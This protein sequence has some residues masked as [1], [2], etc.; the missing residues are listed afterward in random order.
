[1]VA[2]HHRWC[3]HGD[4]TGFAL[5]HVITLFVDQTD[6]HVDAGFAAGAE[7]LLFM[8]LG[9][10]HGD[11]ERAF[12]LAVVLPEFLP[13]PGGHGFLDHRAGHRRGAVDHLA[14]PAHVD[15]REAGV[16]EQHLQHGGHHVDGG[17]ALFL[18]Q[19]QE[20]VRVEAG[21]DHGARAA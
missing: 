21:H 9:A 4:F 6:L 20:G 10:Q 17:D 5:G 13:A 1:M 14:Q 3:A 16:A 19:F 2:G 15:L 11:G 18:D 12:G 7:Q 8:V